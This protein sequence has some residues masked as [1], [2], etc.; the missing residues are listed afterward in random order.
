MFD[1]KTRKEIA[2]DA[3]RYF[4]HG[5]KDDDNLFVNTNFYK[6]RYV[7]TFED[8]NNLNY[9]IGRLCFD[10]EFQPRLEAYTAIL[11]FLKDYDCAS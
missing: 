2:S 1:G 8:D 10:Y 11:K 5:N 3:I 7:D 9:F 4:Y 6:M